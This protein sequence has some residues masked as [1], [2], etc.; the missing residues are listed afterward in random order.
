MSAEKDW[1]IKSLAQMFGLH[2]QRAASIQDHL[3]QLDELVDHLS[4]LYKAGGK[5]DKALL[6]VEQR[7]SRDGDATA[8][9]D[10]V[11]PEAAEDLRKKCYLLQI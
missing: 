1:A 5:L 6:S 11:E 3:R 7:R 4:A 2:I 10:T 9:K 8:G